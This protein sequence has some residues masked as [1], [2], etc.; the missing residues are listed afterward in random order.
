MI[1]ISST[2]R[3]LWIHTFILCVCC[4]LRLDSYPF[5]YHLLH[6]ASPASGV[7]ISR[8]PSP[9]KYTPSHSGACSATPCLPHSTA[10]SSSRLFLAADTHKHLPNPPFAIN[11]EATY[12]YEITEKFIAGIELVGTEA[13][14]CRKGH[15]TMQ[16]G[17]VVILEGQCYLQN[18]HIAHYHRA[19]PRFQHK[20]KRPRRLLLNKREVRCKK[21]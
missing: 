5:S 16:D 1:T 14:S 19:D 2:H 7:G 12:Q 9:S 13:R 17:Q 21:M 3:W 15:V 11:K 18:V 8:L 4:L 20:F 6:G 10:S